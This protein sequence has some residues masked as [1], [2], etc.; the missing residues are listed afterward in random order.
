MREDGEIFPLHL[1]ESLGRISFSENFLSYQEIWSF[2][3][4]V[5]VMNPRNLQSLKAMGL[6]LHVIEAC[7]P[8]LIEDYTKDG[9]PGEV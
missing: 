6:V 5:N 1:L 8:K 7:P 4:G 2:V 9:G 3:Q